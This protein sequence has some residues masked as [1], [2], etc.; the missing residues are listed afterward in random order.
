MDCFTMIAKVIRIYISYCCLFARD[1]IML[2][3]Y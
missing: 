3:T 2:I 1:L